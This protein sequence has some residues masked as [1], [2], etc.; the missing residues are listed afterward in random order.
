MAVKTITK[1]AVKTLRRFRVLLALLAIPIAPA[2]ASAD[3]I[4]LTDWTTSG[5]FA[6]NAAGGGGPFK[7]TTTGT[8]LSV[9]EFI[10]LCIEFNEHFHYGGTYHFALSDNA[11]N[12]GVAGGNPDPLSDATKWLYYQIAS[13]GYASMYTPAT[14]F[15][16]SDVVGA[17]F[18]DAVWYLE[19]ERTLPQIGGDTSAG[20][21]LASYALT[22]QNWNSLFAA[23]HRVYAMNLTTTAGARAQD[24]LAYDFNYQTTAVPEP[25]TIGLF[26]TGLVGGTFARMRGRRARKGGADAQGVSLG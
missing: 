11:V 15:A 4:T 9:A 19:H 22:N 13:G 12:G 10:T 3:T 6:S 20:Y 25:A 23:G 7:A 26:L 17:S 18:Q 8:L 1:M 16:L 14:G 24:Q 5:H 21:L 2:V